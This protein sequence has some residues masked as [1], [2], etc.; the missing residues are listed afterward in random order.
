MLSWPAMANDDAKL[1]ALKKEIQKLQ[2]WLHS[3]QQESD[4]LTKDLRQSD[5]EISKI[6][7][8]VE[9]TKKLL[10]EEQ[11]RLK[12]LQ[13]EQGQLHKHQQQQREHLSE[14]IRAAQRLGNDGPI[15]LLLHQNDPQKAQRM[16]RFFAYF[17]D[18]RMQRITE[19]L[20]EL[21]RLD[22][23]EQLIADSKL[24]LEQQQQAQLKNNQRLQQKKRQQE[25]LLVKLKQ[26]M[27]NE[28]KRLSQKEQDRNRLEELLHEVQTIL[29]SGP[30]SIDARPITT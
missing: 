28:Q 3:A 22:S 11:D 27:T 1:D 12:K 6:N 7:K 21:K 14:Q 30:R 9:H 23:L 16:M 15:K 19:I 8:Q 24:K 20:A 17:N 2:Q 26:S 18:A 29:D 10:L 25:L 13:L 5:L 4:Q